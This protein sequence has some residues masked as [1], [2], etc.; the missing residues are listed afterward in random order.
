LTPRLL[1]F[2]LDGTLVDSRRDLA[3]ATNALL[4]ELG[5][6]PLPVDTVAAMVGEGAA[7]LVRRA[8]SAS[9]LDPATPGAL[10]RFLAHYERRLLVHTRPYHGTR[11]ALV[12]LQTICPLA[13]LTNKP[14]RATTSILDGL[15]LA[16]FFTWVVGGDTAH[17]R[18]PEPAGLRWLMEQAGADPRET[19]L[20]GDSP[21]DRETAVRAGAG[22]CLVRYGFGFLFPDGYGDALVAD[23]PA[24]LVARLTG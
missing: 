8:L 5:A 10:D 3:D 11:E 6:L 1:V 22:I 20:V 12:Q 19:T 14:T 9:G 24:D 23:R 4:V 18:K 21:I 2:D 13:V 16:G 15:D 17:G 7:V